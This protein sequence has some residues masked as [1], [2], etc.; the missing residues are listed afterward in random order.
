MDFSKA[1]DTINFEIMLFKL[2]MYG[3]RGIALN[4]IQSYLYGRQQFVHYLNSNSSNLN[5]STGV[6]Q[7]SIL[8]PFFF[9]MYINDLPSVSTIMKLFFL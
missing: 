3:I 7:G 2:E 1:F 9:I 6:P 5:I 4:W 8:G